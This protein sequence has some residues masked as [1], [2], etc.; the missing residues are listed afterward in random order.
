MERKLREVPVARYD[1]RHEAEFAAGFLEDAGIPYRLQ[2][3][4]PALGMSVGVEATLWVREMDA[5]RARDVL[6]LDEMKAR[7]SAPAKNPVPHAPRLD[8]ESAL[9]LPVRERAVALLVAAGGWAGLVWAGL[10][11]PTSAAG[12]VLHG[13]AAIL[14]LVG[15]SGRAPRPLARLLG[16]LAGG[17]P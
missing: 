10:G 3:D 15:L 17:A 2:L 7:P 14:A 11:V 5:D 6:H 12:Y 1:Y 16:I 4:D 13:L 8:E 9:L